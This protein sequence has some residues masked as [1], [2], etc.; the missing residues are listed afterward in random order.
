MI[1]VTAPWFPLACTAILLYL[2]DH[3]AT[4]AARALSVRPLRYIGK[5]SYGI[6]LWHFPLMHLVGVVP[7]IVLTTVAAPMSYRYVEAPIRRYGRVR[8]GSRGI[9]SPPV[10][11]PTA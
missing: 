11:V 1:A 9:S 3:E 6:Y 2:I 10:P 5:I 7:G 8:K 4:I